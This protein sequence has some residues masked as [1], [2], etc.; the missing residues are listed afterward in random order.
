MTKELEQKLKDKYPKILQKIDQIE[1]RDGWYDLLD[2]LMGKLKFDIEQNGFPSIVACQIKEK[3]GTLRFYFDREE[4][5]AEELD[6]W[7]IAGYHN[8]CKYQNG[9]ITFAEI[10][11]GRICQYCGTNQNIGMTRGWITFCCEDCAKKNNLKG[12]EKL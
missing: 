10:L 3:F 11:S 8:L 5:T 9:L 6:K 1:C 4:K 7:A 12:W 2:M